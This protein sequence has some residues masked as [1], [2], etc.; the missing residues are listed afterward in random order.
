MLPDVVAAGREPALTDRESAFR[1]R[2]SILSLVAVADL[3][4]VQT[5]LPGTRTFRLQG[6]PNGLRLVNDSSSVAR[7]A[8]RGMPLCGGHQFREGAAG[9]QGSGRLAEIATDPHE[10][11]LQGGTLGKVATGMSHQAL[12][13]F[14]KDRVFLGGGPGEVATLDFGS[15]RLVFARPCPGKQPRK[16]DINRQ[17]GDPT[18]AKQRLR[19]TA[20]AGTKC[21]M[22]SPERI[23]LFRWFEDGP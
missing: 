22:P 6:G 12:P 11:L 13:D 18:I 21:P 4:E 10:T 2:R 14:S 20:P 8:T 3:E 23:L 15:E 17:V 5:F 9:A 19:L 7:G 16:D 1:R